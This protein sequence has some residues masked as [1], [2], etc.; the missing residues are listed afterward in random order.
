MRLELK[1]TSCNFQK[2]SISEASDLRPLQTRIIRKFFNKQF[3]LKSRVKRCL[4]RLT[5]PEGTR[6][7]D[8]VSPE[9]KQGDWVE[10]RS[11][12]EIATTLDKSGK[13]LGLYFMPEMERFCGKRFRVFKIARDIKLESNGQLRRLK[14]PSYFLEGVF[15]TGE[16]QGGCDRSC[17]HYWRASWLE[18]VDSPQNTHPQSN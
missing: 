2:D 17:F 11:M 14:K 18:V 9:L 16:H 15:C 1:H 10:V 13:Y 3:T 7:A 12:K 5:H 4:F 6:P 8:H